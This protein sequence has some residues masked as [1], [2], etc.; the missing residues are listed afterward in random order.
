LLRDGGPAPERHLLFS[1]CYPRLFERRLDPV[2]DEVERRP[3]LHVQ[4]LARMASEDE[5]GMVEGRIFSPPAS[6]CHA[7]DPRPLAAAPPRIGGRNYAASAPDSVR[8]STIG[9]MAS[10]A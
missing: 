2:C 9:S 8:P 3:A 5:D 10:V 6:S 4:R 1:G 7:G